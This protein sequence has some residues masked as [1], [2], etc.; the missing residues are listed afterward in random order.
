MGTK[1][2]GNSS[3]IGF[4]VPV[5][6][7]DNVTG[8]YVGL[9]DE[10]AGIYID[11][12]DFKNEITV[13]DANEPTNFQVYSMVFNPENSTYEPSTLKSSTGALCGTLCALG[14]IAIASSDGPA[15]F[16]DALAVTY[17]VACLAECVAKEQ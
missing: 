2:T 14:A 13:Y 5:I 12:T 16:M 6:I 15:P 9:N 17:A 7:D 1:S 10:S 4:T 8:R 11:F 3:G